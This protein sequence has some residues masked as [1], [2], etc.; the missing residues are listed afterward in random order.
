MS[1]NLSVYTCITLLI[2]F[3]CVCIRGFQCPW[4]FCL[5]YFVCF[6]TNDTHLKYVKLGMK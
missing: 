2:L 1:M 3:I 4:V 6:L 5:I